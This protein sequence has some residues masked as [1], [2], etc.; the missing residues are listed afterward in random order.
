MKI[1]KQT[2]QILS[3]CAKIRESINFGKGNQIRTKDSSQAFNAIIEIDEEFPRDFCVYDLNSFIAALKIFN[4]PEIEFK[5][6]NIVIK[7]SNGKAK[8]NYAYTNPILIQIMSDYSKVISLDNKIC[9]FDLTNAQ[10]NELSSAASLFGVDDIE[11]RA[12]TKE[13]II[14]TATTSSG[15]KRDTDNSY[16]VSI[17]VDVEDMDKFAQLNI[18]TMKSLLK[19]MPLDYTVSIYAYSPQ[20]YM[21]EFVDETQ[22]IKY[23][24]GA[25]VL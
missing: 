17:E 22:K 19:L 21:L 25:K 9:T 13:T 1:S 14:V 3:N 12:V 15:M 8:I 7:D 20:T 5:E 10:F 23:Y 4:E 24:A 18:S 11:F 6:S 16:S 2:I